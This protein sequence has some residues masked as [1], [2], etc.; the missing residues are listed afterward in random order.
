MK[1]GNSAILFLLMLMTTGCTSVGADAPHNA[2]ADS[3]KAQVD[4]EQKTVYMHVSSGM[5]EITLPNGERLVYDGADS[6]EGTI[7]VLFQQIDLEG[8][9]VEFP[10]DDRITYTCLEDVEG[11]KSSFQLWDNFDVYGQMGC[12]LSGISIASA[13]VD[14]S[15]EISFSGEDMIFS[16]SFSPSERLGLGRIG[17]AEISAMS[18]EEA[19]FSVSGTQITF[20][21]IEPGE[22][23]VSFQGEKASCTGVP[24][25]SHTGSGTI[26]FCDAAQ[27]AIWVTEDRERYKFEMEIQETIPLSTEAPR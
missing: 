23:V 6:L 16:V 20:S 24:I 27:G 8:C 11:K 15:G 1:L 4:E 18:G 7:P 17:S 9:T 25:I 12:S 2:A 21:G 19:S 3:A 5:F 14:L 22:V 13:T 26:D 10:Y